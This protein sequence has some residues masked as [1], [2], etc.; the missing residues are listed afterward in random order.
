VAADRARWSK[1]PGLQDFVAAHQGSGPVLLDAKQ[2]GVILS[3]GRIPNGPS[4]EEIPVRC[5]SHGTL[6]T[7]LFA[8]RGYSTYYAR[9]LVGPRWITLDFGTGTR[10]LAYDE[11]L[12]L[13]ATDTVYLLSPW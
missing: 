7:P 1:A 9:T 12:Y 11:S 10:R 2:S 3:K 5:S 6:C 4:G 13:P 8:E